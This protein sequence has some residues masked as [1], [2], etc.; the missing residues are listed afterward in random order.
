MLSWIEREKVMPY[1]TIYNLGFFGV[2]FR[3]FN[4]LYRV[5]ESASLPRDDSVPW[6]LWPILGIAILIYVIIMYM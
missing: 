4:I 2:F 6:S 5:I 3:C 1:T